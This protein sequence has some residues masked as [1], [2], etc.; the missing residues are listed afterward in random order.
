MTDVSD[1]PVAELADEE[2]PPRPT[3]RPRDWVR[4]ALVLV[5]ALL[6]L[7]GV[8]RRTANKS[9]GARRNWRGDTRRRKTVENAQRASTCSR[10]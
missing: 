10:R 2:R 1:V 6:V 5:V 3:R 8:S 7:G 9:N 4:V